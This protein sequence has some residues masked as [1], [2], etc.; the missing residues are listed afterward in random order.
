MV[1]HVGVTRGEWLLESTPV[2][3]AV[4][5]E[6]TQQDR[7]GGTTAAPNHDGQGWVG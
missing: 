5:I 1:R 4:L 7:L 2:P 3:Q 6:S